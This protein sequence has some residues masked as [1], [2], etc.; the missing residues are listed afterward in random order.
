MGPFAVVPI[1]FLAVLC[2][3]LLLAGALLLVSMWNI[4]VKMGVPGWKCLVPYYNMWVLIDRLGKPRSWF[5]VYLTVSMVYCVIYMRWMIAAQGLAPMS[6]ITAA[7][8][9]PLMLASS[10][11]MMVY[12]VLINH[13]LSKAFGYDA[14]YTVGLILLPIIFFP[15]LAFGDSRFRPSRPVAEFSAT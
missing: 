14:G 13:A 2:V 1:T 6:P 15:I 8:V 10:C 9:I 5:W 12:G 3:F 11:V 4:Y 7:I